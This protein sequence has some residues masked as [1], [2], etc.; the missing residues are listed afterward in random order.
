MRKL[1]LLFFDKFLLNYLAR[2]R[3]STYFCAENIYRLT[4]K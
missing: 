4:I 2:I 1:F 3:K